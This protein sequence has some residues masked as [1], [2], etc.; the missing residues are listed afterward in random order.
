MPNK[1]NI[2]GTLFYLYI[3]INF[4]SSS[5]ISCLFFVGMYF[6]FGIFLYFFSIY[7]AISGFPCNAVLLISSV[8]SLPASAKKLPVAFGVFRIALFEAVLIASVA[9]CLERSLS[10]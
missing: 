3:F 4:L 1:F 8:I 2:F 9:D 7:K 5:I 10:F 6:S